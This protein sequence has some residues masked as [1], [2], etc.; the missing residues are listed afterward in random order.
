MMTPEKR[1]AATAKG[2]QTAR[3]HREKRKEWERQRQEERDA[4]TKALRTV[5][6]S[7]DATPEQVLEA[8]K[9]LMELDR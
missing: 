2:I 6:D 9:L 5:R 4:T 1:A 7:A 8:V 3:E